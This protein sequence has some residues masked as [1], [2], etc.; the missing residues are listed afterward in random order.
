[1]T[2]TTTQEPQGPD[3]LTLTPA[4]F[5]RD[6]LPRKHRRPDPDALFSVPDILPPAPKTPTTPSEL[7]GQGDLFS[8]DE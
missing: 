5:N 3:W 6:L 8:L 2:T 7:D 4:H 1:M